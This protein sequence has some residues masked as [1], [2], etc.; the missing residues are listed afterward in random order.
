MLLFRRITYSQLHL[1]LHFLL[2]L[3]FYFALSRHSQARVG[4][5]CACAPLTWMALVM[6][7]PASQVE[8]LGRWRGPLSSSGGESQLHSASSSLGTKPWLSST[9]PAQKCFIQ[10]DSTRR[11]DISQSVNA[12]AFTPYV[13]CLSPSKLS[14]SPSEMFS[15]GCQS[16]RCDCRTEMWPTAPVRR[17]RTC[18]SPKW[19]YSGV[20]DWQTDEPEH[21]NHCEKSLDVCLEI[22]PFHSMCFWWIQKSAGKPDTRGSKRGP[23]LLNWVEVRSHLNI[24]DILKNYFM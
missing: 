19:T 23:K 3:S 8:I 12:F 15:V 9:S 2:R 7:Q 14:W 21:Y 10:R 24:L 13:Q 6:F 22:S 4:C 1:A 20:H 18:V 5:S 17:E 16:E 11:W